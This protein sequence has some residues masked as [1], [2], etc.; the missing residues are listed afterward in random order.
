MIH[1]VHTHTHTQTRIYIHDI[2]L[3]VVLLP[4]MLLA[5][6]VVMVLGVS[7]V[8][9]ELATDWRTLKDPTTLMSMT[10]WKSSCGYSWK[11]FIAPWYPAWRREGE[12]GGEGG[13]GER[14]EM[15]N[16]DK[17]VCG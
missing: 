13:G 1:G 14:R 16:V 10:R 5:V 7:V 17:C 9:M 3:S 11:F 2:D 8:R 4:L 12:A 15:G 6:V